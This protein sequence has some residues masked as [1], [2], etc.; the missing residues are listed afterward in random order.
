MAC[1]NFPR[2]ITHVIYLVH[3]VDTDIV[4]FYSYFS[5]FAHKSIIDII[6]LS[7]ILYFFFLRA[8]YSLMLQSIVNKTIF[9][10]S[11]CFGGFNFRK[12]HTSS[13]IKLFAVTR[14]ARAITN[15][16]FTVTHPTQMCVWYCLSVWKVHYMLLRTNKC[17]R[18]YRITLSHGLGSIPATGRNKIWFLYGHTPLERWTNEWYPAR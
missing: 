11:V 18:R 2:S 13:L 15:I 8:S 6:N 16:V 7:D 4:F 17:R 9:R 5:S 10:L 3:S 14:S 1:V 12:L